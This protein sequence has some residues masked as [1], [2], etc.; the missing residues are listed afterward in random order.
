MKITRNLSSS[1]PRSEI[2]KVIPSHVHLRAL[3]FLLAA[4]LLSFLLSAASIAVADSAT[5]N[6]NPTSGD[7]NTAANW[8]PATVPNGPNDTATFASSNI[9]FVSFSDYTEVN[10][11]VFDAGASPFTIVINFFPSISGGGIINNSGQIQNF[12]VTVF[13]TFTFR[14]SASAGTLTV[15][16]NFTNECYEGGNT[17]F[18]DTSTAGSGTF[19]SY[20]TPLCSG[21]GATSFFNSST[22]GN[23]TFIN[24]GGPYAE[25]PG[26]FTLFYDASTADNGTF[27]NNGG[28][29]YLCDGGSTQ[30]F[31]A[32]T[33]GNGNF[34]NNAATDL[35]AGG[36]VTKFSD[37]SSA[38]NSTLIAN[39]GVNGADGGSI[40]FWGDSTGGTARVEV[41]DNG[42]LQ[43]SNHNAPGVTVGSIEGTGL[44]FLGANNLTVG[45]NNLSTNS[46]V[47]TLHRG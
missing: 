38:S 31:G 42:S 18:L 17:L 30:F 23:G 32:S 34:T 9:T 22:A 16:T 6:L 8:T 7:W 2:K 19:I 24:N 1:F 37:T 3:G 47:D 36:G 5:W 44:V 21:P 29:G 28:I 27:T 11:I 12:F 4:A 40:Q 26:G 35:S 45:S 15:F 39:G 41:F 20:G 25:G 14:N 13:N 33:G 46:L 43:I 10:T